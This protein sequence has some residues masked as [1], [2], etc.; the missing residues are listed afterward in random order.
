[1]LLRVFFYV[2]ISIISTHLIA[3]ER[4]LDPVSLLTTT[5]IFSSDYFEGRKTNTKGGLLA[6]DYVVDKFEKVG[7]KHFDDSYI[8]TFDFYN[9][10]YNIHEVGHNVIGYVE[11]KQVTH[12]SD[13]CI[14]IGAHYDHL[15]IF[16][17]NIYNG[18]DDN[19]SG[20][21]ALIEIAREFVKNPADLPIVFISFDAEESRC[22]GSAYFLESNLIQLDSILLFVNMDMIS[23]SDINELSVTGV[24]YHN[25]Y[26]KDIQNSVAGN[27]T[28]KFGHDRRRDEGLNNWVFASDHGEFHKK[29]IPFIYFGVEEHKDYHRPSDT[30]DGINIGFFV[31]SS[32]MILAFMEKIGHK[33]SLLRKIRKL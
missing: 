20:V 22:A 2:L 32:A 6:R 3:Q 21:A 33:K 19:A 16:G 9:K 12:P 15:G 24:H 1:M 10:L 29:G 5:R 27:M 23:K 25:E 17:T 7:L 26:R 30:F 13:G 31:D 18:A 28:V 14:I 4:R 11:G 8:Q